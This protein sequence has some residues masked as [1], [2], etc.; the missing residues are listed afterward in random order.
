MRTCVQLIQKI[1]AKRADGTAK[2]NNFTSDLLHDVATPQ[3]DSFA[4][5]ARCANAGEVKLE[6]YEYFLEMCSTAYAVLPHFY[7]KLRHEV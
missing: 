5:V 3:S 4:C 2:L 7:K 6:L 1:Q